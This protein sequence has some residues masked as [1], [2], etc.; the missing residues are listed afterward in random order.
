MKEFTPGPWR[1]ERGNESFFV[2]DCAEYPKSVGIACIS[3]ARY[4]NEKKANAR[5]IAAAPSLLAA[6][7]RSTQYIMLA[8]MDARDNKGGD[9][10]LA[11]ADLKMNQA[12]IAKA[13]GE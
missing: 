11:D 4:I 2:Y 5:L 1:A 7:E 3:D 13:R 10:K 8:L 6:L 9:P 12:A